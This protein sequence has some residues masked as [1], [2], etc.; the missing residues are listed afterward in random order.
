M[1]F[2][3]ATHEWGVPH[4]FVDGQL[5]DT[6]GTNDT[7]GA[8]GQ[9]IPGNSN[10][11]F[12]FISPDTAGAETYPGD[13]QNNFYSLLEDFNNCALTIIYK[14]DISAEVQGILDTIGSYPFILAINEGSYDDL[15][16]AFT[17]MID[18]IS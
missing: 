8:D 3:N 11:D 1:A 16:L 17:T 6:V 9:L 18:P 13:I 5:I 12:S 4:D 14:Y 7:I 15:I 10:Y 2:A